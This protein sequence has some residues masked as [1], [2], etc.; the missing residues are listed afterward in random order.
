MKVSV[1]SEWIH[2]VRMST[3]GFWLFHTVRI[4]EWEKKTWNVCRSITRFSP[5]W[6]FY[7]A[8]PIHSLTHTNTRYIVFL[9][10][11]LGTSHWV[12]IFFQI[13]SKSLAERFIFFDSACSLNG[14]KYKRQTSFILFRHFLFF[15]QP[16]SVFSCRF[17]PR[18]SLEL[19]LPFFFFQIYLLYV[20][21]SRSIEHP[22]FSILRVSIGK[23]IPIFSIKVGQRLC[24]FDKAVCRRRVTPL[25]L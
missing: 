8:L 2:S 5:F 16:S 20:T 19:F 1:E 14:K 11:I 9:S 17:K 23:F 22:K 6:E 10:R 7:P 21:S 13:F 18:E 25:Q 24:S 12:D 3:N 15:I 4:K